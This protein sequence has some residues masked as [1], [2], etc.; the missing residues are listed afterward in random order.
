MPKWIVK[1]KAYDYED[2]DIVKGALI[3]AGIN[4]IEKLKNDNKILISS[5]LEIEE[6]IDSFMMTQY[7]IEINTITQ[8][9]LNN[10]KL[11]LKFIQNKEEHITSLFTMVREDDDNS[12]RLAEFY[13]FYASLDGSIN[14]F[15]RLISYTPI[16]KK[17]Y[18]G[19]YQSIYHEIKQKIKCYYVED[20]SKIIK[21]KFFDN[22]NCTGSHINFIE[23]KFNFIPIDIT[24][25]PIRK[26]AALITYLLTNKKPDIKNKIEQDN[27]HLIL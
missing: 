14:K 9:H 24:E 2:E 16:Y 6:T 26:A 12:S 10:N 4:E 21:W 11:M 5:L 15:I 23:T 19:L 8:Q 20:K 7:K 17:G 13:L 27:L 25:K 18:I 3:R 22:K 1:T